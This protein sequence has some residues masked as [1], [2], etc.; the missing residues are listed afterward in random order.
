MRSSSLPGS[1]C[2]TNPGA[3]RRCSP[4]SARH[5]VS[6]CCNAS[7]HAATSVRKAARYSASSARPCSR[8]VTTGAGAGLLEEVRDVLVEGAEPTARIAALAALLWG[9]GT[10]PQF[11]PRIP[12]TSSVIN[13]AQELERGNW[14]A[15]AVGEAVAR[16]MTA[17]IVN[18]VISS[19]AVVSPHQ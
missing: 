11:D 5:S 15:G 18:N 1:M 9:S 4:R 10:L 13:R 14:S 7:S 3:S 2:R 8:T 12:W 16:T 6:P 17:V 19:T